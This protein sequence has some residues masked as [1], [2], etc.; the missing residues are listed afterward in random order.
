M[1]QT[2]KLI[3]LPC[4][5]SSLSAPEACALSMLLPI[6]FFRVLCVRENAGF[7]MQDEFNLEVRND[8]TYRAGSGFCSA[9]DHRRDT[10][11]QI[12]PSLNPI[13][14]F[15]LGVRF[16]IFRNGYCWLRALRR[17]RRATSL[18]E[19]PDALAIA[20]IVSDCAASR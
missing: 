2:R 10:Q 18:C 15:R 1:C 14:Q 16:S 5:S 9:P 13:P 12:Q 17:R 19:A 7:T 11:N 8:F 6:E 3:A 4:H 20:A